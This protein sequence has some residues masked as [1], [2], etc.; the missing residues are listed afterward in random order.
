[1]DEAPAGSARKEASP[2]R[3]QAPSDPL[4]LCL[5]YL[6]AH[7]S[8]DEIMLYLVTAYQASQIV[9]VLAKLGIPDL[10]HEQ[11]ISADEL[12]NKLGVHSDSLYRLLR[13]AASMGLLE[14]SAQ[15]Q[16][17]LT[18][19]GATLR[20]GSSMR[21]RALSHGDHLYPV[22]G[23]LLDCIR[24]G[25]VMWDRLFGVSYWQFLD[26]HA[27]DAD[28]F[29]RSMVQRTG[30]IAQAL[31]HRFDFA[32][33]HSLIDLGG[34]LGIMMREILRQHPHMSGAILD[35]PHVVE[36]TR[37][38][39]RSWSLAERCQV[40]GGDFVA[41]VPAGFDAYLIASALHNWDDS[42]A[43]TILRN[44]YRAG[45]PGSRL[46]LIE[47]ILGPPNVGVKSKQSDLTM[48][49]MLGGRERSEEEWTN[50]LSQA[51]Y[52]V[53][54]T[55]MLAAGSSLIEAIRP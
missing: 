37:Q 26:Q 53:A 1:M 32:P 12:A 7:S 46:L 43:V 48:M 9:Y 15:R 47:A 16:F 23:R 25:E 35:A 39:L 51:G 27:E 3:E 44:C 19:L 13:C 41:G 54:R 36:R 40:I 2:K 45:A 18:A 55:T 24:T 21:H 30:L 14:E 42:R 8:P 4:Q 6:R 28:I 20:D 33:V 29:H 31:V 17:T 11:V 22:F 38:D 5:S 10:L 34:G 49:I 52:R 50:L